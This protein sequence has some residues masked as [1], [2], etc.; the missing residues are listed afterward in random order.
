[1]SASSDPLGTIASTEI[2]GTPAQRAEALYRLS[3]AHAELGELATAA[4]LA[5]Q[6]LRLE[7]ARFHLILAWLDLDRGAA[8]SSLRHLDLAMPGL[9]G[10]DLARAR[11]LRGLHL[12]QS[13]DPR[14][15][16]A[17][18]S[19]V[20]RELRRHRDDRWLA[21]ALV[22]RGIARSY[23]LRLAEADQ[24]FTAAHT[25]LTSLGEHGRAAMCLHNKGF[26]ATLAGQLPRA[27]QLYEDAAR[28]GLD[29]TSRPEALIDRA[30][31]LLAAGLVE[32]ARRVLRPALTMLRRCG[33]GSRLP[34]A[35]LL[36]GQCAFRRHD[37][38]EAIRR[39]EQAERLFRRQ[40][41]AS[42]VPNARAL[43]L[44][45]RLGLGEQVHAE[46]VGTAELCHPVEAAELR[47]AAGDLEPVAAQRNR[48]PALIRAL[49]WL[50]RAQSA[51][52]REALRAC[53]AGLEVIETHK[54]VLTS[55]W[56][57]AALAERALDLANAPREVLRWSERLRAE[58]PPLHPPDDPELARTLTAL[59]SARASGEPVEALEREVRRRTLATAR[60]SAAEGFELPDRLVSFTL[61]RGR[62]KMVTVADG[63]ARLTTID[64]P[65]H[66]VAA[67]R[68]ALSAGAPVSLDLLPGHDFVVVPDGSLNRMPW[69]ALGKR[70]TVA[71]SVRHWHRARLAPRGTGKAWIAG[72]GLR[73]ARREVRALQEE[74]GG[75][76]LGSSTVDEALD[77]MDGVE[78]AHIA[79]HGHARTDHPLFS[80]IELKDGPLYGHDLSKLKRAPEI[81][82]LSACD[83]G[84]VRAFLDHGTRVVIASVLP[85]PDDRT[86][87]V[88]ATLHRELHRGAP[89]A[90]RRA[91]ETT[92]LGFTCYG[93]G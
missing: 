83:S 42:W 12:C 46:A 17:E 29:S 66:E 49:G 32:D 75:R 33:R 71:P 84:L 3:V 93:A 52:R 54:A 76:L 20:I 28:A 90:V 18:L 14:L 65:A 58:H 16:I 53:R 38:D 22:G 26:V 57:R 64:D 87:E 86:P 68:I 35:I 85:V 41:R 19:A 31:A 36:A 48:G 9:T 10:R 2:T 69:S 79:A 45:A 43:A 4:K 47:L 24:D 80:S 72:P 55:A 67:A 1:M 23:A 27:L 89:E 63:R 15:A 88:M 62:L 40:G 44:K 30:E 25:I 37:L 5:R 92:N 39:A 21:N 82:V 91:Q 13:S 78:V 81:V 73:T 50:A 7:P 34:E 6:G 70:V 56:P 60:E 61:H 77:A 11:V 59:R 8:A 74:H 51:D